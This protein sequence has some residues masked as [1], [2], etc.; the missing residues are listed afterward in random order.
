MQKKQQ[1]AAQL[2]AFQNERMSVL[3]KEIAET[4]HAIPRVSSPLSPSVSF[5]PPSKRGSAAG[6]DSGLEKVHLN[7]QNDIQ[8]LDDFL[9]GSDTHGKA[10]NSNTSSQAKSAATPSASPATR[11]TMKTTSQSSR[12]LPNLRTSPVTRAN[13]AIITDEDLDD[14][15]NLYKTPKN[16]LKR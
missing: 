15:E 6:L 3:S 10:S 1:Y 4:T 16:K 13:P 2:E 12:K 9:D 7:D 14:V 11:N 8:N 5:P